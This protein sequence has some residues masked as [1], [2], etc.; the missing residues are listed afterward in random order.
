M[1]TSPLLA[2]TQDEKDRGLEIEKARNAEFQNFLQR[3][4]FLTK[5]VEPVR[6]PDLM[7]ELAVSSFYSYFR[8]SVLKST[9]LD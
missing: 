8:F 4:G 6:F 2:Q 9:G 1:R 5:Q 3:F 7:D